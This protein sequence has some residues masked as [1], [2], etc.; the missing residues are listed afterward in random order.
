MNARSQDDIQGLKAAG[1]AVRDAFDTMIAACKP[2]ITTGELDRLGHDVLTAHG[3]RSA[4]Q[5]YY[6][7]P[8]ATCISINEHAAH[9]I[10]GDRVV[11]DG[12][13]INIDVSATGTLRSSGMLRR[14]S[15]GLL[16]LL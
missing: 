12:D 8:G 7:F 14:P 16:H 9:G 2:G 15:T 5:L 1:A 6:E 4:P 11:Q 13:M 3:A 10:P